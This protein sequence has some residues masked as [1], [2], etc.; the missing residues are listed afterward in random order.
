[1]LRLLLPSALVPLRVSLFDPVLPGDIAELSIESRRARV[2]LEGM[3]SLTERCRDV[4]SRL[5][6]AFAEALAWLGVWLGLLS[7]AL[8]LLPWLVRLLPGLPDNTT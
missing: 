3:R 7:I 5:E 8:T 4:E 6:T 1:M 2:A